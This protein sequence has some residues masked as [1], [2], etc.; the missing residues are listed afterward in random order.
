MTTIPA[1]TVKLSLDGHVKFFSKRKTAFGVRAI[2]IW[3]SCRIGQCF[4]V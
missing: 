4:G 1:P 2:R 3:V